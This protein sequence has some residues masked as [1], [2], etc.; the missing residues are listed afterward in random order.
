M[1]PDGPK[2]GQDVFFPTN[3]NLTDILGRTDFD[4]DIFFWI[5]SDHKFPEIWLG[6]GLGPRLVP[7]LG[8]PTQA[9]NL[10]NSAHLSAPRIP[11]GG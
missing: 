6:P 11:P 10:E 1:D 8:P 5:F 2:W 4:F 3:P 9:V 7:G